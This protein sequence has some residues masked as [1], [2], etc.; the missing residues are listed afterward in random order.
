M[1]YCLQAKSLKVTPA[2]APAPDPVPNAPAKQKLQPM[3][4]KSA[5]QIVMKS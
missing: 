3:D 2:P 5:Q 4:A 1:L